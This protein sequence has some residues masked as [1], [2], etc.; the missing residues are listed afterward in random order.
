MEEG[1]RW[2]ER[3]A[4]YNGVFS[5][6]IS[7][8]AVLHGHYV[9]TRYPNSLPGDILA[10]V[11]TKEAAVALVREAVEFVETKLREMKEGR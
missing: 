7:R 9:P 4:S 6:I 10:K 11:Y 2:L 1:K 5:D 8:W 3:A